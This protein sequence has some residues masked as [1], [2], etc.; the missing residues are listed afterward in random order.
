MSSTSSPIVPLL[1]A[2]LTAVGV[3][4]GVQYLGSET[5]S[6]TTASTA[7]PAKAKWTAT[8]Q[9]RVEPKTGEIKLSSLAPGRI[10]D[11][12]V[13]VNDQVKAGDLLV[14]VDDVDA[15]ARM[16]AADAEA[17]VRRRE[18]DTETGVPR[19]AQDRRNAEDKLNATERQLTTAR[20][21]LDRL[22]IARSVSPSSV[23]AEQIAAARA[24]IQETANRLPVEREALRQSQLVSG[25]PLPTRL[26]AGL[27]ASRADLSLAEAALERTRVRAPF[28]GTIL[29]VLGRVGEMAAASPEQPLVIIGDLSQLKVRAEVEERYASKVQVGQGVVLKSDA[30]SDR[31]FGGKV[32]TIAQAMRPPRLAQ[33]GPRRPADLDTLEVMIDVEPGTV[34]LPGM[35]VDVFFKIEAAS[36]QA[37]SVKPAQPAASV[38]A[39][40]A[41]TAA[42]AT[43]QGA[44]AVPASVS[45]PQVLPPLAP[46]Q[47]KSN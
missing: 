36:T 31:E 38:V 17:G 20:L 15:M 35:R 6:S 32:G 37:P 22:L 12:L 16:Q 29:Q 3:A 9:G 30:F 41:R 28:D 5:K 33:R 21:A 43:V 10:V 26:E 27:T 23:T 4:I 18:R 7:A 13:G 45:G 47:P 8:A 2:A 46:A 24:E 1:L 14:M 25:V 34:L 40:P 44:T 19:L 11:V 42:P 39:P